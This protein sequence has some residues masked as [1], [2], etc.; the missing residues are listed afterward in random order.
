M[1]RL[2][3]IQ[4]YLP[5][6]AQSQSTRFHH[7]DDGG[8]SICEIPRLVQLGRSH[9][10]LRNVGGNVT[11]FKVAFCTSRINFQCQFQSFKADIEVQKSDSVVDVFV[12]WSKFSD[13]WSATT[14]EHT[15]EDPPKASNLKSITQLQLWTEGVEGDFH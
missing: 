3:R 10:G 4:G 9:M 8:A 13:K 15:A 11:D 7:C 14:G 12:P 5:Y 6:S 1:G 2:R